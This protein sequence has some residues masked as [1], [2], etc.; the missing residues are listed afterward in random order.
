MKTPAKGNQGSTEICGARNQVSRRQTPE[1]RELEAKQAE[2]AALQGELAQRELDLATL[3]AELR[4][5]ESRYLRTVGVKYAEFDELTARIAE[6]AAR[7]DPNDTA[8]R[9]EARK[10]RTQAE[11]T[12]R[13]TRA[14]TELEQKPKF[15]PSEELKKL[16][17]DIAKQIHP[18]LADDDADRERRH[19]SM[20][21]ANVA[22]EAGDTQRLE[23]ILR[24]W[25]SSPD[26]VKGEGT[27]A[28]LVRVIRKIA[29][30]R[31]RLQVIEAK[32]ADLQKSEL[33]ELKNKADEAETAGRDLLAQI[34][35]GIEGRIAAARIELD[36]IIR[37]TM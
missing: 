15:K 19:K 12:A 2:L 27:A 8:A 25:E 1:E 10:A 35:T 14:A 32:I 9:E 28:E 20:A 33:W 13:Q 16:Y 4:A 11:E 31:E 37:A 30:A 23:Q 3:Q 5:F 29:Q 21:E 22:F 34:A 26:S 6:A 18:D 24:E 36:A 7:T 17:R